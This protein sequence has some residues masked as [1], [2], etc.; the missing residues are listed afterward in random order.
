YEQAIGLPG[1]DIRC[2]CL[3][4]SHA[5]GRGT[6]AWA[7]GGSCHGRRVWRLPVPVVRLLRAYRSGSPQNIPPTGSVGVPPLSPGW[8]PSMGDARGSRGGGSRCTGQVLGNAR[9]PL[10]ESGTVV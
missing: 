1:G 5:S 8:Y 10:R 2:L 6:N 3:E 9:P 4:R 7:S